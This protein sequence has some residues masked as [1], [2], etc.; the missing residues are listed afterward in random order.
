MTRGFVN[1][2]GLAILLVLPLAFVALAQQ[3]QQTEQA[4]GQATV[5]VSQSDQYGEY[6]TDG[7]GR[8]LYLFEKE[9]EEGEEETNG[10]SQGEGEQ[11]ETEEG[12]QGG[13][14]QEGVN[15]MAAEC[16]DEC[17]EAWPPLVTEG[18][19]ITGE[20]VDA[21]LLG[22]V[23]MED[24]RTQVTTYN[25]WPLYYFVRDENPGDI[26]GQDL[27]SFGGEWYIVSPEGNPVEEEHGEGG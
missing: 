19:P 16:T 25:G 7:E 12:E 2:A 23:T 14:T 18:E 15:P 11:G 1:T 4:Q 21:S 27:H 6:L 24:G 5:Q 8:T 20:G 9:H 22:T 26:N 13:T 17:L 10:E 3:E